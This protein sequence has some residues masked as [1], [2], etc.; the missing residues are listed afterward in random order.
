MATIRREIVVATAPEAA[1]DAVRDVGAAHR[2]FPG[3][4]TDCRMEPAGDGPR[5][6][7]VTFANGMQVRE[8]IVA[9]DDSARR[10]AWSARSPSFVH[11]SA[12]IEVVAGEDGGSRL[13]WTADVLPDEVAETVAGLMDAGAAALQRTLTAG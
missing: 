12:A 2:L 1:W 5:A 13:L 9:V 11:H 8:L 10:F 6:R 3:V 4:L 7:V